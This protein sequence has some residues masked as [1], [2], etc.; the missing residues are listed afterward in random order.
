MDTG[1]NGSVKKSAGI[2]R[3]QNPKTAPRQQPFSQHSANGGY[4]EH[5]INALS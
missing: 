5:E 1:P 2:E 4:S 3:K